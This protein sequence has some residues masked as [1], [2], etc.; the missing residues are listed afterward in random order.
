MIRK[1]SSLIFKEL[2]SEKLNNWFDLKDKK[3]LHNIDTF[4][5]S[6]KLDNDFS[7]NTEDCSCLEFRRFFAC[8]STDLKKNYEFN[9][10][11][12]ISGCEEYQLNLRP[13]SYASFYT[14]NISCPDLFDIFIA[15]VVP[16]S[17]V[18]SEILVQLRS[19]LLWQF[20]VT[21]AF[22]YS[23]DCVKAICAF[24]HLSIMD[25]KENR[26]D[27]C[28]HS[29]YLRNPAKFFNIDNFRNMQVS[30]YK[31]VSYHY[32]FLPNNDVDNDYIALGKRSDKCFVR[33][34]NKTREV[35][36]QGYKSWFLKEW[37]FNGLISRYDFY[38]Y[39]KALLNRSWSYSYKARLEFYIDYGADE[40]LINEC[41][42]I[43]S[44]KID[45]S[46]DY[47]AALANC[48]TPEPT[49]ITNVEF[50]TMRRMSKSFQLLNLH[51]NTFYGPAERIY[52]YID[53]H[54]L[55]TEYLTRAS[56]RLVEPN[57]EDTNKSR[58]DYCSF[59]KAL[60]NTKFV[61][62]K[63][64]PKNI[65]LLRD[66]SRKINL[67]VVKNRALSSITTYS[68]Y[69]KGVNNDGLIDD[70]AAFINCLNDNDIHK[71]QHVKNKRVSQI[72]KLIID[73]G[74]TPPLGVYQIYNNDTGE[75]I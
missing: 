9:L 46:I 66:Y 67:E 7:T 18:T 65:R 17:S 23:Y 43:L 63:K 31:G 44:G 12:E 54:S 60:R 48:L 29:N 13:F 8:L 27:Y 71:M 39:E 34:Y 33:I 32:S 11:I 26:V 55:I 35:V 70:A 58:F 47:I 68:L 50:Q 75:I 37:F 56:L 36:E 69:V 15:P 38:V 41:K 30:R 4:Y 72:S 1:S 21:K 64:S 28:W 10:P 51:D 22:E 42:N 3:F 25:V 6:V 45:K 20:G 59:W 61:D 40:K 49:I 2:D 62:A 5:Y 53:N 24:F 16:G 14:I 57:Q 52:K 74:F 19:C 73:S